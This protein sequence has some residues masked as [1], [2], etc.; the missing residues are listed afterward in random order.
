LPPRNFALFLLQIL[1]RLANRPYQLD[2]LK[3]L[4][5]ARVTRRALRRDQFRDRHR[6]RFLAVGGVDVDLQFAQILVAADAL[7][8]DH[9]AP[10]F[11]NRDGIRTRPP[12]VT[13]SRPSNASSPRH[14]LAQ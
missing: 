6:R 2:K 14:D 1:P 8:F 7:H 12:S 10:G 11:G 13:A 4:L 5:R 9:V 3:F